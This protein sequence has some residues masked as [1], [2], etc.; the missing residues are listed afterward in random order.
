M[1]SQNSDSGNCGC[2][3]FTGEVKDACE[4]G[5][6]NNQS[7][8]CNQFEKSDDLWNACQMGRVSS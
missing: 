1:D 6:E 2:C 3:K 4:T 7:Y 8:I 5:R